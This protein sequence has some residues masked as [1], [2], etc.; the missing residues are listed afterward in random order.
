MILTSGQWG[1]S[2]LGFDQAGADQLFTFPRTNNK[3]GLRDR[4]SK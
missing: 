3:K 2:F 1:Y 4:A